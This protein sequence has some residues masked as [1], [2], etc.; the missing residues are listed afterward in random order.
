MVFVSHNLRAVTDL[1]S[2]A[3]HDRPGAAA[4]PRGRPPKWP[5]S[6][7]SGT[8]SGRAIGEKEAYVAAVRIRDSRGRDLQFEAGRKVALEI[9]VTANKPCQ[10]LAVVLECNDDEG[11]DIFN[12]ST[13][14]LGEAPFYARRG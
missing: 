10:K 4:S 6:T 11:Y 9:D 7:W 8:P 5:A 12:T 3:M 14:R 2:R 1:C 13:E